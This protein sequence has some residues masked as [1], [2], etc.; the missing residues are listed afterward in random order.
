MNKTEGTKSRLS[1]NFFSVGGF[2]WLTGGRFKSNITF[3]VL[4]TNAS[5]LFFATMRR[6]EYSRMYA[7]L[8]F[9]TAENFFNGLGFYLCYVG[10]LVVYIT[11]LSL[12]LQPE[13]QIADV[14][15]SLLFCDIMFGIFFGITNYFFVDR[16]V[17][18]VRG[19]LEHRSSEDNNE[20]HISFCTK[21]TGFGLYSLLE[22]HSLTSDSS[23]KTT[24]FL[25]VHL[26][27]WMMRYFSIF[28]VLILIVANRDLTALLLP[29]GHF[30]DALQ[31]EFCTFTVIQPIVL[32]LR[33]FMGTCLLKGVAGPSWKKTQKTDQNTLASTR[34]RTDASRENLHELTTMSISK[35]PVPFL[36]YTQELNLDEKHKNNASLKHTN[37]KETTGS[38][39]SSFKIDPK[40]LTL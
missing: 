20:L 28:I 39:T 36:N 4:A 22:K 5:L 31:V 9:I 3:I 11:A 40:Y 29:F 1:L 2:V 32:T 21:L 14:S 38:P 8:E 19:Q 24:F 23:T 10:F 7:F 35:T 34:R 6:S 27:K 26:S 18:A 16:I 13:A 15:V 25:A 33:L 37:S 30:E 12:L 17:A